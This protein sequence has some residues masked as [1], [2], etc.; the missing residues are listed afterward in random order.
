MTSDASRF[1]FAYDEPTRTVPIF[2]ERR[3]DDEPTVPTLMRWPRPQREESKHRTIGS[4]GRDR[5]HVS[6]E[7]DHR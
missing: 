5:A 1:D 3:K 7:I 6:G 2:V 4:L